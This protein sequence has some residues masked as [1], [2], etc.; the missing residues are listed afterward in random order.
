MCDE[1][2]S[3]SAW[4]CWGETPGLSRPKTSYTWLRPNFVWRI[5]D[6]R[7]VHIGRGNQA[8]RGGRDSDV[9]RC[10]SVQGDGAA[11]RGSVGAKAAF[12]QAFADHGNRSR[13]GLFFIVVVNDRP[14]TGE[15]PKVRVS[16][17]LI[18]LPWS[19]S[20]SPLPVRV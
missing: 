2:V 20:G 15:M 7:C 10:L 8:R 1:I 17:G 19:C 9:C 16:A 12:P 6:E 13:T 3:V 11:D 14:A 5:D 18:R 4:G